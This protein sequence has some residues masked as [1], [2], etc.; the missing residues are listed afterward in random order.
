MQRL[1]RIGIPAAIAVGA[2]SAVASVVFVVHGPAGWFDVVLAATAVIFLPTALV[3][4][5]VVRARSTNAAGWI[6]L[7]AGAAL[8]LGVFC[9]VVADAAF[10][11]GANDIPAPEVFALV[12][13]VAGVFGVPL[14]GTLGVLL[15]PDGVLRSRR[16]AWWCIGDLTALALWALFSPTL[17]GTRADNVDSPIGVG[18]A[19]ALLV[20]ILVIGPIAALASRSLWRQA[21]ATRAPDERRA[22]Q[23]AARA[24]FAIPLAYLACLVVG[25]AGGDTTSVGIVEN[26]AALA[27]GVAS[28]I[29]IVRYGLFDLRA[30]LGRS[31]VYGILAAVVVVVYA[32]TSAVL[33]ELVAGA[34]PTVLAAAVA[35]LSVLPLHERVQRRVNR[36][37][38]GL[39]NDPAA[40]FALLGARLDA[41]AAPEDVLPLAVATVADALRLRYVAIDV[42]GAEIVR[43][44]ERVAGPCAVVQLPFAGRAIGQLVAQARDPHEAFGREDRA[45]L[46]S[47][48]AQLGLAARAVALADAERASRSRLAIVREEERLRLRRDLHDELGSTLAGLALGIDAARRSLPADAPAATGDLMATLRGEAEGAVAEIRRIAYN[49]RP[50]ILDDLGLCLALRNQAERFTHATV[51]APVDLPVLS[52]DVEV[53]AYRIATEAMTNAARHAPEAAVDVRISVKG[54]DLELEIADTGAGLPHDLRLGVG[55]VSM[56]ERAAELGGQITVTAREPHGTLVRASLPLVPVAL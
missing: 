29:G 53:A 10:A 46:E 41:A 40:A 52:S 21:V 16:L 47:L 42:E 19:G 3:G 13:G 22:L 34:L 23:L 11:S 8:P 12:S 18:P 33:D 37:I 35:A 26:T 2:L 51:S 44:G 17:L 24:S 4:A 48:S 6:L 45:L 36:L 31:I 1:V 5:A 55:M 7:V 43:F 25:F 49:L 27:I 20:A 9:Q 38:F 56:Q 14:V 32:V 39:R 54:G 30:V 15:F 28:W 50:P